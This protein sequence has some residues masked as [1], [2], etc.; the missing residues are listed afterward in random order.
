M[1]KVKSC[2]VIK[3][4]FEN[5][6]QKDCFMY[7][8]WYLLLATSIDHSRAQIKSIITMKERLMLTNQNLVRI[9]CCI[10]RIILHG[11]DRK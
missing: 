6:V 8:C 7:F 2:R 1:L 10:E 4:R 11:S 5:D 3:I 9:T